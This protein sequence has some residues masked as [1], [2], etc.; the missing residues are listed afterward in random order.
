GAGSVAG[1]SVGCF[2]LVLYSCF[3][4]GRLAV[5]FSRAAL[6]WLGNM[7]YSYY[8][9]HGLT[10]KC[11][12]VALAYAG[13]TTHNP[14]LLFLVILPSCLFA[15]WISATLLFVTIEKPLSL[16]VK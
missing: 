6:R 12:A 2:L 3:L 9:I 5:I 4:N 16:A 10:L 15:T 14:F 1:L 13:W 11:I 8:L 7:S